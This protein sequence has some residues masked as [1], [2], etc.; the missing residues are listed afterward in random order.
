MTRKI[1]ARGFLAGAVA[2]T[3]AFGA[4]KPNL[5]II[6]A[7][8][9]THT[10]IG[11]YGGQNV[12]TPN[13]DRLATEGMR[14]THAYVA[15]SMCTPSRTELYTGLY[16]MS[17][18]VLWNHSVAKP[19]TKSIC[20]YL[21]D[22]GYRVGLTGKT[23]IRPP[24]TFP[25]VKVPGFEPNCVA[26]TAD[27]TC[28]GIKDFMGSNPEQP[29]C[30][31]VASTHSHMP[32]TCGDP[33]QFDRAAIKLPPNFADTPE[34][35][36]DFA[37]YLAEIAL[38]DQQ[39]GDVL[40]TL[41]E[42]GQADNTL[43]LL[44]SEQG[45]QFPFNKWTCWEQ[46]MHTAMMVRWPG[47]VKPG[48][49]TDALVQYADVAPTFIAAAGGDASK[50]N[51]DGIGFLDVLLGQSQGHRKYVYGLHNNVPEG[52]PYPI[53]TIRSKDFRYIWNLTPD[54][55]YSE[56]HMEHPVE[57]THWWASWKKANDTDAHALEMYNRYR[58]RPEEQLYKSNEDPY[59]MTDLAGNPEYAAVKTELRAELDKWM[60]QQGD[61]GAVLDSEEMQTANLKNAPGAKQQKK[62]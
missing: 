32:W 47:K 9:L 44:T 38:F 34:M 4:Q 23:H 3:A 22:Q 45:A 24:K 27:Y 39:V 49:E 50:Y 26:L 56:K 31:V 8:D 16:P 5:L 12:K 10:E 48:T 15:M 25:F 57:D 40:R 2:C 21:G 52:P 33:D 29:F 60:T 43:V 30:L 46:G 6:I 62:K 7:D 18:G 28:D 51:L 17:S 1:I 42:T 37:K 55:E 54:A 14:F 35:R 53:R 61:P 20:H 19:G 59:E 13:I 36:V 11:C 58:H 41:E